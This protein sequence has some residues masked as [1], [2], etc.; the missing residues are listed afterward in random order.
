M[1]KEVDGSLAMV[2][3]FSGLLGY[4]LGGH[5]LTFETSSKRKQ[6]TRG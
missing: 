3:S 2:N 6:A 1:A 5:F 4:A